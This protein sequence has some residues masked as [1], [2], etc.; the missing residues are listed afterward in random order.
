MLKT[1]PQTQAIATQN[2]YTPAQIK[3]ALDYLSRKRRIAHPPGSFDKARRF[4][5]AERTKKTENARAPSR[6]FP[7]PEMTAARTADHVAE[8]HGVSGIAV[9]RIARAM[10]LEENNPAT[11]AHEH[12]KLVKDLTQI[13]KPVKA[14]KA[15]A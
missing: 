2:G 5:A 4:T 15:A 8:V 10:E 11:S 13:L 12:L 1:L 6:L 7:Y 3:A 14:P 9:K